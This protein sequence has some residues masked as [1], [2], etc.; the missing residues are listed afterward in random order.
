MYAALK[1]V[2]AYEPDDFAEL[3][4]PCLRHLDLEVELQLDDGEL[5][6]DDPWFAS[7]ELEVS[8]ARDLI[9]LDNVAIDDEVYLPEPRSHRVSIAIGV[10]LATAVAAALLVVAF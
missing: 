9:S 4:R 6:L 5:Q 8:R 1:L 3:E 10:G 2:P 7:G